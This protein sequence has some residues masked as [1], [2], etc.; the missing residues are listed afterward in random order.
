MKR[1]TALTIIFIVSV[2]WAIV[3]RLFHID[4]LLDQ[5]IICIV[6]LIAIILSKEVK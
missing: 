6:A 3:E 5:V 4:S 1:I 2:I